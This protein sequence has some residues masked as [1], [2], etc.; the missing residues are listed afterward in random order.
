MGDGSL[1]KNQI[2][3]AHANKIKKEQIHYF[4]IDNKQNDSIIT[5]TI[6]LLIAPQSQMQA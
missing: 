5:N 1:E 2:V 4:H 6:S 3:T